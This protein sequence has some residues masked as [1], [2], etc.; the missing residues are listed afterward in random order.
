MAMPKILD[1]PELKGL[2]PGDTIQGFYILRKVEVKTKRDGKPYLALELGDKSGR[3][4]AKVW[5]DAENQVRELREGEVAKLRGVV[6]EYQGLLDVKIDRI[7][8]ATKDDPVEPEKLVKS[9]TQ[10]LDALYQKILDTIKELK[11]EHLKQLLTVIFTDNDFKQ[12]FFRAPGGKL[13]HHAVFGGLLEH[14]V[15][16]M[17]LCQWI[18]ERYQNVDGELLAAGALLHDIG[19]VEELGGQ[20]AIDYTDS[21]RLM[22]HLALGVM[23]V[24]SI[25]QG[26]E[27]FP[28]DLCMK[29]L[30]LTLSHHGEKE[31]GSPVVP[32]M[33]E[34]QILYLADQI[35]SQINAWQHII[36]RDKDGKSTWSSYVKVIDRFLY[37]GSP[38]KESTPEEE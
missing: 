20:W 5:E 6:Q 15:A 26:L 10:D 23:Y 14:T 32:Q 17:E 30:H 21:G 12:K 34:A 13:W 2:A 29:L 31:S 33:V 24:N 3:L 8:M 16:V 35:D 38:V 22:G 27:D 37:L 18:S 28:P 4:S 9:S 36:E 11:N 1:Q 7:R 25:I 19:K